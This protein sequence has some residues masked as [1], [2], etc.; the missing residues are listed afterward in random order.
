MKRINKGSFYSPI[1]SKSKVVAVSTE[2]IERVNSSQ[3]LFKAVVLLDTNEPG[4]VGK[5]TVLHAYS[6]K[7]VEVEVNIKTKD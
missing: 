6:V 1:Q 7:K 5:Q 4:N 3:Y 2:D